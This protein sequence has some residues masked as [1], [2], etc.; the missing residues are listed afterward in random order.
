MKKTLAVTA[1]GVALALGSATASF[2]QTTGGAGGAG[3]PAND[4][5]GT[6]ASPTKSTGGTSM[7]GTSSEM[8]KGAVGGNNGSPA[9]KYPA[10]DGNTK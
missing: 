1:L 4:A 2:A 8:K 9:N 6:A 7:G 3:G 10:P 5:P